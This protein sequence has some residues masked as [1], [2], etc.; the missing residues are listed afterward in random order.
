LAA[1]EPVAAALIGCGPC[2]EPWLLRSIHPMKTSIAFVL[3]LCAL[4]PVALAQAG[5]AKILW[6][7]EGC[8][9]ILVQKPDGE[10]GVV[11]QLSEGRAQV[12]DELEGDFD[13]INSIRKMVNRASGEEIM[14]RGV[15]YSS[16]RKYVL[17]VMP[18]WCKAPKE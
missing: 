7:R 18:K 8:E 1:D 10:L 15:R 3:A 13:S 14:M 6:S 4:A 5:E 12:G 17:Q 2:R 11:L 16:S 9:M